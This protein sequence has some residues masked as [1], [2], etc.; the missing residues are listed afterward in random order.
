MIMTLN[1]S[2]R[3][4]LGALALA[5]LAAHAAPAAAAPLFSGDLG[6]AHRYVDGD[7]KLLFIGDSINEVPF[8]LAPEWLRSWSDSPDIVESG[9]VHSGAFLINSRFGV[10]GGPGAI[11]PPAWIS[12]TV[13][14]QPGDTTRGGVAG[15]LPEGGLGVVFSG[16]TTPVFTGN[17]SLN[18][19]FLEARITSPA[20]TFNQLDGIDYEHPFRN[21][22]RFDVELL[23]AATPNG[24][25]AGLAVVDIFQGATLLGSAELGS[26]AGTGG[27]LKTTVSVDGGADVT[28]FNDLVL[29]F[30][31][32]D[33]VTPEA[34]S[35][36]ALHS[37]RVTNGLD[38]QQYA[39]VSQSGKG[40]RWFT[41]EATWSDQTIADLLTG[42]DTDT[43]LIF[44]GQND[45]FSIEAAAWERDMR[46]LIGR[47]DA[48]DPDLE[49]ILVASYDTEFSSEDVLGQ[50][51]DALDRI[52]TDRDDALFINL[53]E[54]AGTATFINESGFLRDGVH[55]SDSGSVYF[56]D[57][58]TELIELA[59]ANRV[60]P[61]PGTAMLALA[62]LTVMASRRRRTA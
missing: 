33:Q 52:A 30:R 37:V 50:Y 9:R 23:T 36:V 40:V 25:D 15:S 16:Q 19:A 38:G 29:R 17:F 1:P 18:N 48:A 27:L 45:Y 6:V 47:L 43:A 22:G 13:Q 60:I 24:L 39:T 14:Y 31:L 34:G 42:T 51:A 46:E 44:L 56:V 35:E 49:Y 57:T 59:A 3:A 53:F 54:A 62:G 11:P 20:N 61:E 2:P 41:D 7:A 55:P 28:S 21:G 4:A 8:Y 5:T 26:Q 10:S 12:E 58:A 32:K